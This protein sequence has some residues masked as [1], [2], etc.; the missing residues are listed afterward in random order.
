MEK[1]YY[2]LETKYTK[3]YATIWHQYPN[4]DK[5]HIGGKKK[6]V[7]FTVYLDGDPIPNLDSIGYDENCNV[8]GDLIKGRG[9]K[10][11]LR[12]AFTFLQSVYKD[13]ISNKVLVEDN[14]I[15]ACNDYEM[16]LSYY[17]LIHYQK[18]WYKKHFDAHIHNTKLQQQF[19][20]DLQ[21]FKDLLLTKPKHPFRNIRNA[22]R[23]KALEELYATHPT[24][25]HFFKATKSLD[26]SVY[27]GWVVQLLHEHFPYVLGMEWL[28][29]IN[30]QKLKDIVHV[31]RLGNKKPLNMFG[32]GS[33]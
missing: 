22:Q 5:V 20:R 32:A 8:S 6:C 25:G 23:K 18:T 7:S 26:C 21:K 27:Q 3:Y 10:H 4:I 15:I 11:I 17:Y 33:F 9:T 1:T 12:T 16:P 14:S 13:K 28:I 30:K 31:K 24:L 29:D 2:L 19:S